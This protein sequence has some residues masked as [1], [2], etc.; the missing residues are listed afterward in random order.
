[1]FLDS[2]N[3]RRFCFRCF[4]DERQRADSAT[5]ARRANTDVNSTATWRRG[6]QNPFIPPPIQ[7]LPAPSV[8]TKSDQRLESDPKPDPDQRGAPSPEEGV[9]SQPPL[10]STRA[11]EEPAPRPESH[12]EHVRRRAG[13]N[14]PPANVE[15]FP[16]NYRLSIALPRPGG[17]QFASEMITVSARRGGRLAIVADAWHLEHDCQYLSDVSFSLS[18]TSHILT[19]TNCFLIFGQSMLTLQVIMNGTSPFRSWTLIWGPCGHD[20][21]RMGI[22]SSMCLG[23]DDR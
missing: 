3:V 5:E 15:T 1:V 10:S 16:K 9:F 20:S 11:I 6:K 2:V 4:V 23:G 18:Q 21:A 14:V 13:H 8:G 17:A 22:W 7:D 19:L 12:L